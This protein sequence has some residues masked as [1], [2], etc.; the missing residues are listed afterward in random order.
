MTEMK[1]YFKTADNDIID[2]INQFF[3]RIIEIE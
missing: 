2:K 3:A 1:K